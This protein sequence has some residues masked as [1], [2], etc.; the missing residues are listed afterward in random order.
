MNRNLCAALVAGCAAATFAGEFKSE[1]RAADFKRA[2]IET[3]SRKYRKSDLPEQVR[4]S[5]NL[6]GKTGKTN[7]QISGRFEYEFSVPEDGWY[8]ISTLPDGNN[9]DYTID[10]KIFAPSRISPQPGSVYLKAGKHNMEISKIGRFSP[11]TGFEIRKARQEECIGIEIA[12]PFLSSAVIRK[13]ATFDLKISRSGQTEK[14]TLSVI[15]RKGKKE[16]SRLQFDLPPSVNYTEQTVRIP[17]LAEGVFQVSFE[18]DSAPLPPQT[19]T[20]FIIS[21][22]RARLQAT[23]RAFISQSPRLTTTML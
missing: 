11:V 18:L 23:E 16:A 12:N 3:G 1:I 7:L 8:V 13:N 10:G 4:K 14:R 9:Y 17:T 21:P 22:F 15:L 19:A 5:G 6:A 20:V 2:E